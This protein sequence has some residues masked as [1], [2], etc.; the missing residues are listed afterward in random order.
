MRMN[1]ILF[2]AA[3]SFLLIFSACEDKSDLTA[4]GKP[5]TGSADFTRFVAIGN[6]LTAGVQNN[7]VYQGAQQYSF[8]NLIAKQVGTNFVMPL[9]SEPG[10]P[11]KLQITNLDIDANGN[12]VGVN[13]EPASNQGSPLNLEY[14]AP[15][16]NLGISG[17]ILYDVVDTTDF[18]AKSVARQNPFFSL[19][20]RNAA[21]G[22]SILAQAI[23]QNPTFVTLWIGNNDVL[24]YATSGGTRGTDATGTQPTDPNVFGFLYSQIAQALAASNAKVAVANIPNVKAI[25]YFATV[26]PRIAQALQAA[27]QQNPAIQ[28]LV[29]FMGDNVTFN[30]ASISDLAGLNVLITLT[31]GAFAEYIGT[32]FNFYEAVGSPTPPNVDPNFPFGVTPQ[33]PWPNVFTLDPQEIALVE[34]HV[35]EFNNIIAG[36]VAQYS[37]NFVLVDI[38]IV[39]NDIAQKTAAGQAYVVDGIP[40]TSAFVSGMLFGLD[41]VHPTNQGYGI[42]ANSFIDAINNKWGASIPRINVGAIPAGLPLAKMRPLSGENWMPKFIYG[43]LDNVSYH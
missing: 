34:Q 22:N 36:L 28:G 33:N 37:S 6:S 13:F 5:S 18:N 29:Y 23:T 26:G 32:P 19:V 7:S 3:I 12:V 14:Q 21:F 4:P 9:I 1:K 11:G 24:G 27:Q 35:T 17:A 43:S 41:G 25:P 30:I 8:G 38:H 10:I 15:Y 39:F 16:N 31:G 20:L 40:F 2:T 42:V